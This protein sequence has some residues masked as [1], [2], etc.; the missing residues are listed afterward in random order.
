[1]FWE[2]IKLIT[3]SITFFSKV[4]YNYMGDYGVRMSFS[5]DVKTVS[6]LDCSLTSKYPLLKG[7]LSGSG[8]QNGDGCTATYTVT[9]AHNLGYIPFAQVFIDDIFSGEKQNSP[10]QGFDGS[11]LEIMSHRCD[12]TNLY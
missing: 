2:H 1:M 5:G 4:N 9:V 12:A 8:T 10:F 3:I 6:D 11:V 7:T